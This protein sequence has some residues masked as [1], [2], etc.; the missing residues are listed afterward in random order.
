MNPET[1]Q[2]QHSIASHLGCH[3]RGEICGISGESELLRQTLCAREGM[4]CDSTCDLPGMSHIYLYGIS[5]E[6]QLP[7]QVYSSKIHRY[8]SV[9]D[10]RPQRKLPAPRVAPGTGTGTSLQEMEKPVH[11]KQLPKSCQ[12]ML[13]QTHTRFPCSCVL[14]CFLSFVKRFSF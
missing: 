4:D 14:S 11:V 8:T 9:Q 7:Q 13:C 10:A 5:D 6:S 2:V 1:E 3:A 12:S